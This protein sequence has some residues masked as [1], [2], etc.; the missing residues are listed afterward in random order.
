MNKERNI[1]M[2]KPLKL[3]ENI[4]DS[5]LAFIEKWSS[6]INSWAWDQRWKHRDH[7]AWIK[8]YKEWK[9]KI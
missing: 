7:H 9:K 1:F 2:I 6:H 4:K 8:G 3:W 5:I